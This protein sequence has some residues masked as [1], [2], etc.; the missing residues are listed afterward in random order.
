MAWNQPFM[1]SI[2]ACWVSLILR[3][4]GGHFRMDAAFVEQQVAQPTRPGR[5]AGASSGPNMMSV[6]LK[7]LV[8]GLAEVLA[9][10][11]SIGMPEV[12]PSLAQ[13][14]RATMA[15]R[16]KSGSSYALS[17]HFVAIPINFSGGNC[18]H[19]APASHWDSYPCRVTPGPWVNS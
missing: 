9:E 5:G 1:V 13:P 10:P 19:T 8:L 11:C 14:T 7:A 6:S 4:Q 3:G 17:F 12:P 16:P 15:A 18:W 2:S